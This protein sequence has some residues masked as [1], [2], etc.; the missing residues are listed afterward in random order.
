MG[1]KLFQ[2]HQYKINNFSS[3][4][5]ALSWSDGNKDYKYTFGDSQIWQKFDSNKYNSTILNRF[6]IKIIEDP[7]EFLLKAYF[8]LMFLF[9]FNSFK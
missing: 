5:S 8:N 4:G 1:L 7:F 2:A 9:A 6:D 3:T